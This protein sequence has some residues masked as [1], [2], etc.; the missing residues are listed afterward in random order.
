MRIG[1]LLTTFV[2]AGMV[3]C[4][5]GLVCA[6]SEP[7]GRLILHGSVTTPTAGSVAGATVDVALGMPSPVTSSANDCAFPSPRSIEDPPRATVDAAGGY[8]VVLLATARERRC[9]KVRADAATIGTAAWVGIATFPRPGQTDSI[10]LD[11]VIGGPAP[12]ASG[13]RR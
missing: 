13:L 4:G 9:L 11:I 6:C 8:R 3:S 10:R 5:S 1:P 2:A 12:E 7:G